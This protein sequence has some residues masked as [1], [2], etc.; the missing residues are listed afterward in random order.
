MIDRNQT[1]VTHEYLYC[2]LE[3]DRNAYPDNLKPIITKEFEMI[4]RMD[5]LSKNKAHIILNERLL[6]NEPTREPKITL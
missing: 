3:I 4:V 5:W 1:I 2:Q 6:I